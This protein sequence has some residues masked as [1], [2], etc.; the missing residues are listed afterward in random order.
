[1][2]DL[3]DNDCDG[4][5]DDAD[6]D[7]AAT[8]SYWPDGDAD[9]Y[10]DPATELVACVP[11][12]GTVDNPDDCDD[13]SA[14]VSPEGVEIPNNGIDEDCSGGDAI[15]IV[16]T[17]DTGAPLVD[18]DVPIDPP[19]TDIPLDTG[20]GIVATPRETG[21]NCAHGGMP[22]WSFGGMLALVAVRRRTRRE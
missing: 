3:L 21:C 4:L 5:V 12:P 10:G 18:T 19:E 6:P 16:E 2:C 15:V 17:A 13:G 14:L 7:V 1:V 22:V 8:D 9:G 11:P 20:V